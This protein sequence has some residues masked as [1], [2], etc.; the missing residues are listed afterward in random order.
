MVVPG[1]SHG[2]SASRYVLPEYGRTTKKC[3]LKTD[4]YP[5]FALLGRRRV[6]ETLK[7]GVETALKQGG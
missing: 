3:A 4:P 7:L 2:P 5:G 1:Q 6:P